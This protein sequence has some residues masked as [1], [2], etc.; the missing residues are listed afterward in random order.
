MIRWGRGVW[1]RRPPRT[2]AGLDREDAGDTT[3]GPSPIRRGAEV[4]DYLAAI[5]FCLGAIMFCHILTLE[6][7]QDDE[8]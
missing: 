7:D 8:E 6:P 1:G 2:A 4:E 5:A 3:L